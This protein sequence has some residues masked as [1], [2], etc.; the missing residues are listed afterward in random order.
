[1]QHLAETVVFDDSAKISGCE[2][3]LC[4]PNSPTVLVWDS[5][6]FL[7]D[8]IM[9]SFRIT[10]SDKFDALSPIGVALIRSLVAYDVADP[11]I[12]SAVLSVISALLP[13]IEKS[14]DLLSPVLD[15][16]FATVVYN[17]PGETKGSRSR[18]VKNLRRHATSLFVRICF[19][20]PK[21]LLPGFDQLYDHISR[22]MTGADQLSSM[23][24]GH[25]YEGLILVSNQFQDFDK[26]EK[27][28]RT[29]LAQCRDIWLSDSI[30]GLSSM[31][32][33]QFMTAVGLDKPAVEPS[34]EDKCG[35]LRSQIQFCT[36]FILAVLRRSCIPED[37]Q[38][39]YAGGFI[40]HKTPAGRLVA[41]NPAAQPIIE[42]LDSVVVVAGL[43]NDLWQPESLARRHPDYIRAFDISDGDKLMLMGL[44]SNM[45]MPPAIPVENGP[46]SRLPYERMQAFLSLVFD[47]CCHIFGTLGPSLGAQ[48]YET[49]YL[50]S[51]LFGSLLNKISL[52][53]EQKLRTIIRAFLKPYVQHCPSYEYSEAVL[54]ILVL[55]GPIMQERLCAKWQII[56]QRE[57]VDE[58]DQQNLEAYE[59]VE[60]Q[61]LRLLTREYIEF[62]V[63]IFRDKSGASP[64]NVSSFVPMTYDPDRPFVI[65]PVADDDMPVDGGDG[66]TTAAAKCE[67]IGEL[68]RLVLQNTEIVPSLLL[69]L[70][71][72]L[73]WN[74]TSV[75][76]KSTSM[77]FPILK[78]LI[79]MRKMDA[80]S[81]AFFLR[82]IVAGLL[83]HGQH[84]AAQFVLINAALH[85]YELLR[86]LFDSV[87][88]VML[89]I[90]SCSKKDLDLFDSKLSAAVGNPKI[91]NDKRKKEIF[92]KFL[93]DA[94][95]KNVSQQFMRAVKIRDLA[96]LFI[97]SSR[98]KAHPVDQV[99]HRDIG[100]CAL[101]APDKNN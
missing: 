82:S 41:R 4:S 10:S 33:D 66:D 90:P 34:S 96:P 83:V 65:I 75:C 31:S 80:E 15:R 71:T 7:F 39:S 45:G 28:I 55:F 97:R 94:I 52:L 1:M 12:L 22:L 48:F 73:S 42:L 25:L 63:M 32:V 77:I 14:P 37:Y 51:T 72:S 18:V 6:V 59:I 91:M 98:V 38:V 60:E 30:K 47:N 69:T 76:M 93:T 11:F 78:Q 49:P 2:A 84:D 20:F 13:F 24:K 44:H 79:G 17:V 53:P 101:F 89:Q 29:I 50:V 57:T 64:P 61:I 88:T 56:G 86:P 40:C 8:G 16:L 21:L 9:A 81:A 54:P 99:E 74:D 62:L 27:F 70:L 19:R 67:V 26:Q 36:T 3:Q 43:L 5:L 92:K 68:G 100:L 87:T 46:D 23:E 85:T 95:G 58:A 35:I